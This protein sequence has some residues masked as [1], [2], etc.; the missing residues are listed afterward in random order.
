VITRVFVD[1]RANFG[2]GVVIIEVDNGDGDLFSV[3]ESGILTDVPVL[4]SATA[5]AV[6]QTLMSQ[7]APELPS[8]YS[9]QFIS[10]DGRDI[11]PDVY[12]VYDARSARLWRENGDLVAEVSRTGPDESWCG[13]VKPGTT[14]IFYSLDDLVAEARN[15]N[16]LTEG[17]D[18]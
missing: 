1:P 5:V 4:E 14:K 9:W 7:S 10:S 2:T 3:N 11:T 17:L 15:L 12:A 8:G 6:Y 18:D 13:Q 16:Y